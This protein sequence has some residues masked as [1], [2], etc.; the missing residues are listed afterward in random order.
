MS[1]MKGKVLLLGYGMQGKAAFY[2]LI[3]SDDVSQVTVVDVIP[4]LKEDIAKYQSP[5]A[6][7]VVASIEDGREIRN[8]MRDVDVVLDLLP[9][10]YTFSVLVMAVEVGVNLVSAM[11]YF[12]PTQTDETK[13]EQREEELETLQE[14]A[15]EKGISLLFGFGME[16][17]LDL[18]I[19]KQA[20][21]E[22]DE[23]YEYNSYGTDFPERSAANN[24][25]KY[26]FTYSIESVMSTY[27]RPAFV[28]RDG[29]G[30]T[31]PAEEM[32]APAN[33]HYLDLPE[34]GGRLECYANGH[35]EYCSNLLGIRKKVKRMGKYFCRW[36]GHGAIWEAMAK[37]GFLKQDPIMV[38]GAQVSPIE[39][40]MS[41]LGG[42]S[43]F[44]YKENE[45]DIA[46]V[47]VEAKGTKD[48]KEKSVVYQIVDHRDLETGFTA[49]ART[50]GFTASLGAKLI[51]QGKVT[52]TGI[53]TP[54]DAKYED[55]VAELNRRGIQ[56]TVSVQ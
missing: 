12:D 48:G 47:R 49:M 44:Y 18:I 41:L 7:A 42:Q 24:P 11:N 51:L 14:R 23:V 1:N 30:V 10:R 55:I 9:P 21:K 31:I 19:G 20:V 4:T 22:L 35:A 37:S 32:F 27:F 38:N 52:K 26:K 5:K 15:K 25:L 6:K 40:C 29:K 3:H 56:V 16:P 8:L 17:G 39:F 45:R 13:R 34:L 36:E 46:L 33:I 28:I 43:Q 54:L 50:A 2:D 53:L